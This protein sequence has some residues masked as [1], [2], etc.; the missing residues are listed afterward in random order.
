MKRLLIIVTFLFTLPSFGNFISPSNASQFYG[1]GNFGIN[2]GM[3][4]EG[5]GF[6]CPGSQ[7]NDLFRF[8]PYGGFIGL[9]GLA[10]MHL[11]YRGE[12]NQSPWL[13]NFA[14]QQ[15]RILPGFEGVPNAW[16]YMPKTGNRDARRKARYKRKRA[17]MFSGGVSISSGSS[18]SRSSS[19]GSSSS[20]SSD[21]SS[22]SDGDSSSSDDNDSPSSLFVLGSDPDTNSSE[23]PS[24][25]TQ[26]RYDDFL[27][28][29]SL[30]CDMKNLP[31]D[32]DLSYQG[33]HFVW[34]H[35]T[36]Y[37]VDRCAMKGNPFCDAV[38]KQ[39]VETFT[40]QN[41]DDGD[42]S[43]Q[44]ASGNNDDKK[45]APASS[46]KKCL[47]PSE[48]AR[49]EGKNC[50]FCQ[51]L[52]EIKSLDDHRSAQKLRCSIEPN[53]NY[54][55]KLYSNVEVCIDN[56][57]DARLF[58]CVGE[59]LKRSG[60]VISGNKQIVV[61]EKNN[62]CSEVPNRKGNSSGDCYSE[63]VQGKLFKDLKLASR[64]LGIDSEKLFGI[65]NHESRF[66][67]DALGSD[68]STG[69]GQSIGVAIKEVAQNIR[70][71]EWDW[72]PGGEQHTDC[73]KLQGF[74]TGF[75]EN[76]AKR[77]GSDLRCNLV[78]KQKVRAGR[79]SA[80]PFY[81]DP[82]LKQMFLAGTFLKYQMSKAHKSRIDKNK[83][84]KEFSWFKK[85]LNPKDYADVKDRLSTLAYN[86]GHGASTIEFCSYLRYLKKSGL[87]IGKNS[88]GDL[89]QLVARP[90]D[91]RELNI[92][93]YNY[94]K[95]KENTYSFQQFL[96]HMKQN[97]DDKSLSY[98]SK[99]R[100]LRKQP[101]DREEY[102]GAM[103]NSFNSINKGGLQCGSI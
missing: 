75:V 65:V 20:S 90:I 2:Q 76:I 101:K 35:C 18:S 97:V 99:V 85:G 67:L 82:S 13:R 53:S 36:G 48:W 78:K 79:N 33:V 6:S 54:Y 45:V 58:S 21:S 41:Q 4:C 26:Q 63:K 8:T 70:D 95:R 51:R 61:N 29:V 60:D 44:A 42:N 74:F 46:N 87:K 15:G 55:H 19:G 71:Q 84:C 73:Q 10:G 57:K 102:L 62:K 1:G 52:M 47:S 39:T 49:T 92:T 56:E 16:Y 5:M 12:Y 27:E 91:S 40:G 93:K 80:N 50:E 32:P 25:L 14:G 34:D 37:Q 28:P 88:S 59:S 96:H 68:P 22:G 72:M 86:Y 66:N 43:Q 38:A 31:F 69:L 9:P 77:S 98:F 3:Y 30:D 89:A 100:K 7:W 23:E 11:P 24:T 94:N 64:C 81:G 17:K 103:K 83:N